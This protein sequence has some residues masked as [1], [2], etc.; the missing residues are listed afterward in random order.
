MLSEKPPEEGERPDY[1]TLAMTALDIPQAP[2]SSVIHQAMLKD[3]RSWGLGL[4]G[5]G[6]LN[7]FLS[8]LLNSS[9]GILLIVVGSASFIFKDAAMYVIYGITLL[10]AAVSNASSD[11]AGWV[12]FSAIQ[13]FLAVGVFR[14]FIRYRRAESD[15]AETIETTGID[16]SAPQSRAD[17]FFP[18]LGCLFGTLSL[19]TL[20]MFFFAVMI[21]VAA[22]EET[23]GPSSSFALF[24]GLAIDLAVL[25]FAINLAALLS[26]FRQKPLNIFG[27]IASMIP[28]GVYLFM[29]F[30]EP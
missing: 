24:L 6:I 26:R 22:Q 11:Q 4:I 25:G 1:G 13:L 14:S 30:A 9:W 17:R 23:A 7:V 2:G 28:I 20:V 29:F 12:V 18:A 3:I 16:T 27:L 5:F 19:S 15:L 21:F 8:G 10:W